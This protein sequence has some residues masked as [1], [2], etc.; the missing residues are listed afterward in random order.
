MHAP[1]TTHWGAIKHLLLYLN[2]TRDLG[3]HL[4]AS[5]PMS[6]H[7]YS[8]ADWAGN[9]DDRT[10]TGAYVIFLGVNPISWS[11]TKQ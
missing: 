2:G 10:S 5:T 8:D 11:S 6:L 4:R 1:T 3:I 9:V 7:G